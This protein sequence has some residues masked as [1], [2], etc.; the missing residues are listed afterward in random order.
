MWF[1]S[2]VLFSAHGPLDPEAESDSRWIFGKTV[3]GVGFFHHEAHNVWVFLMI[4]SLHPIENCNKLM[5]LSC[6]HLV[7][8]IIVLAEAFSSSTL[9][10]GHTGEVG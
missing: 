9:V 8:E 6:F 2:S 4:T 5:F 1:W 3:D 7:A 10:A